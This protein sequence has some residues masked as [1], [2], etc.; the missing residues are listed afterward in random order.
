[1]P[2]ALQADEMGNIY[3]CGMSQSGFDADLDP[4]DEVTNSLGRG[5][6]FIIKYNP[7]GKVIW[8]KVYTNCQGSGVNDGRIY[9]LKYQAGKLFT[10]GTYTCENDFDPHPDFSFVKPHQA[11]DDF[12]ILAC[13]TSG[14]LSGV[15]TFT[16]PANEIASHI[17]LKPEGE[18]TVLGALRVMHAQGNGSIIYPEIDFDPG[19][20]VNRIKGYS[21]NSG[22]WFIARYTGTPGS[23]GPTTTV[24]NHHG[25]KVLRASNGILE[26]KPD[27]SISGNLVIQVHDISGRLLKQVNVVYQNVEGGFVIEQLPAGLLLVSLHQ[28]GIST[29]LIWMHE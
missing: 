21:E 2:V 6:D 16:G 5:G 22:S 26:I 3:V 10:C 20:G 29:G 17:L 19:V 9:D 11:G 4:S 28:E 13:D 18:I 8:S 27:E 23:T 14:N 7:D 25:F 15:T 24:L 1:M 12:Y